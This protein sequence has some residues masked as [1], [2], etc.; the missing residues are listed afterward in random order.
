MNTPLVFE[1]ED[2]AY[3]LNKA[4]LKR[5]SSRQLLAKFLIMFCRLDAY[6]CNRRL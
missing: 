1:C 5:S 4:H 3:T 2:E 6:K